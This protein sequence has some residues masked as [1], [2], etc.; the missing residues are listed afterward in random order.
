MDELFPPD[1]LERARRYLKAIPGGTGAYSD[2]RGAG[3]LR[4]EV[5]KVPVTRIADCTARPT[6]SVVIF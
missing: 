1:V 3:I 2:S 5:A 6:V 4:Q